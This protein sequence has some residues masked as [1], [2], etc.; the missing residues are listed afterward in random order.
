MFGFTGGRCR[1]TSVSVLA[2]ELTGMAAGTPAVVVPCEEFLTF[3]PA[4]G[5]Y[6][7]QAATFYAGGAYLEATTEP[8]REVLSRCPCR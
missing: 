8:D 1:P 2:G 4:P 6:H 7:S 3:G 5:R